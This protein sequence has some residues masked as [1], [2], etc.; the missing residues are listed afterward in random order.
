MAGNTGDR[1]NGPKLGPRA[2]DEAEARRRRLANQL[3][4]NLRRRKAQTR[5]RDATCDGIGGGGKP[6]EDAD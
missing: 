2:Q 4:S 6:R 5:A 1:D 3:R